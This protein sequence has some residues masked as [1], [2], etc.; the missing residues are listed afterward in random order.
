MELSRRTITDSAGRFFFAAVPVGAHTVTVRAS[1]SAA[2]LATR[3]VSVVADSAL[4]LVLRVVESPVGRAHELTGVLVSA[5]RP[6]HVIGHLPDVHDGVIF[7]G[8]KTEV[9][10]MDSLH[11]NLALDVERQILGRV[12]GAHFSET[13]GAGFPS[14]GVGFRGLD[15]TQSVEVNTR[16]NGVNLAADVFGYPETYYTP[17]AQALERIEVVRGAGSLAFGPQFGGMI[18]YVTR[19]GMPDVN[20]SVESEQTLGSYGLFNSFNAVGGGDGRST[21]YGFL[22]GRRSTGWRPNSDLW[23]GTAFASATY[24]ATDRWTVGMDV[25]ASRNR[26]HMGGGLSDEQFA[27]DPTQSVRARNW[28]ANPW[29]IGSVRGAYDFSSSARLET[30]VSYQA[31]DRHLVWRNEDGGAAAPDSPDPATG[32][33]VP[34]EVER[35]TFSNATVESRLRATHSLLGIP[36]TLA[37]G[38]RAS[39]GW[40]HRL[41]GGEGTVGQDFDMTVLGP[42][43]RDLR[44]VTTNAALFAENL[45]RLGSLSLT[46][47]ARL[48]YIRSEASGYTEVTSRFAPRTL[49]FPL[50]GLGAEYALSA[51]TALYANASQAYRPIL[52][53]SLT[54]FGSTARVAS[55]LHAARGYNAEIG[56]RGTAGGAVKFDL[57][58][59]QLG[60]H[61]RIGTRTVPQ[62]GGD[63]VETANVG[64]SLHRGVEGY[65]ELDPLAI[66]G[67]DSVDRTAWGDVGL[68]TSFAFV[69]AR[70]VSGPF[71]G[72]RVEQAP[73]I[74]DRV[75]VSYSRHALGMTMQASHT[76][77]SYGDANNTALSSDEDGA[78]GIV[79]AYTVLDWSAR[80]TLA[81]RLTL[82][83]GVN[84]LANRAYFTKRS[85]EYP[86]PGILPGLGRSVYAGVR[87]TF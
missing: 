58:V 79:P 41:E 13:Q 14:N 42:W 51:S 69:D 56:W 76:G 12:P 85:A 25:T 1:R 80:Y 11:A 87:T 31:S 32:E 16:Q 61:D 77:M 72:R 9:I 40:M 27:A 15:P 22:H 66:A 5:A 3:R 29:N 73:R 17:P 10:V 30:T 86:G 81:P 68:F 75:G 7:S 47:G 71:T 57:G 54:P 63:I 50:L 64:S 26:I 60:Y 8:K 52:N 35:E 24:R 70:Y 46:P 83:L 45:M 6:L 2:L 38:V 53:A 33:F 84:N 74:V 62:P 43:E 39:R 82:E 36:Q 65:V 67:V 49:R 20:T 55:D 21:Y 28:L 59:F 23:Q 18:N 78:V 44:F 19:R 34:R 48:E 4:E 37:A